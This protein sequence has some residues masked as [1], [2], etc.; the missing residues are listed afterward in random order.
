MEHI[1]EWFLEL[2]LARPVG[3]GPTPI[4]FSE[5]EAYSRLMCVEITP[6]EVEQLRLIDRLAIKEAG[7]KRPHTKTAP[8]GRAFKEAGSLDDMKSISAFSGATV[9]KRLPPPTRK[10]TGNG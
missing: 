2:S 5:I 10:E 9:V 8:D 1:W 7:K 3:Y 6:W 4:S